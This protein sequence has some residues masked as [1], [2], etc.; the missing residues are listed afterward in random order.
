MTPGAENTAVVTFPGNNASGYTVKVTVDGDVAST[1][2]TST[3]TGATVEGG[4]A[5]RSATVTLPADKLAYITVE[6]TK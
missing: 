4:E 5:L 6:A 1:V 3:A 2:T